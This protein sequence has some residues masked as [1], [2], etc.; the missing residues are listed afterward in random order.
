MALDGMSD[1]ASRTTRF[2]STR[3]ARLS[4][5][6]DR[7]PM[8]VREQPASRSTASAA[9]PSMQ[10]AE[11]AIRLGHAPSK[12]V[13]RNVN[14]TRSTGEAVVVKRKPVSSAQRNAGDVLAPPSSAA[15]PLSFEQAASATD[16]MQASMSPSRSFAPLLSAMNLTAHVDGARPSPSEPAAPAQ[17]AAVKDAKKAQDSETTSKQRSYATSEEAARAKQHEL[18]SREKRLAEKE[19][20][21]QAQMQDKYAKKKQS[22]PLL[23]ARLALAGL[24]PTEAVPQLKTTEAIKAACVPASPSTTSLLTQGCYVQP[25]RSDARLQSLELDL[26]LLLSR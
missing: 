5:F 19:S 26:P 16:P 23:A 6:H 10:V 21:R 7:K 24:Q 15:A 14:D 20:R 18:L 8:T 17:G 12:R 4:A 25:F 13:R 2:L 1:V 22:D 11:E 3:S 9:A